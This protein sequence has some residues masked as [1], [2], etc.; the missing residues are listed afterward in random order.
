[1]AS[2]S[3]LTAGKHTV[4]ATY[5]G[6]E[7]FGA[8]SSS[9]TETINIPAAG[10]PTFS[11]AVGTYS[12]AQSVSLWSSTKDA[13]I[14]YTTD[15]VTPT[16][17]SAVYSKPILVSKTTT[18]KAFAAATGFA[19]SAISTGMFTINLGA[20]PVPTITPGTGKFT[21]A[22]SV[23]IVD[24]DK[25]AVI[26]YTV[27]GS[28]PT[29]ASAVYSKAIPVSKTTTVKALAV[30]SGLTPSAVVSATFTITAPSP[31]ATPTFSMAG[32]TFTSTIWPTLSDTTSGAVIYYTTDGSTPTTKSAI[33]SSE[34]TI[35]TTTTVKAIAVAPGW[36]P[37]AVA[38]VTYTIN[39]GS[40]W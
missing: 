17:K 27:D 24:S 37:S 5:S 14:Y 21:A 32:G 33:Y 40:G 2:T 18:F 11:P 22:Q 20:T 13:T 28:T 1:V 6:D 23:T 35:S 15:G 25:A 39:S 4:T 8:S 19:D 34:L 3:T 9:L 7:N 10:A 30:A 36:A 16:V 26:H 12:K 29:A 31:T 38:S